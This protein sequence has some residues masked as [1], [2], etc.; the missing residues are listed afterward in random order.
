MVTCRTHLTS[1]QAVPEGD[2]CAMYE[3]HHVHT[4]SQEGRFAVNIKLTA[5]EQ[6]SERW[7]TKN[8]G[9]RFTLIPFTPTYSQCFVSSSASYRYLQ[10]PVN[11]EWQSALCHLCWPHATLCL[12]FSNSALNDSGHKALFS[13]DASGFWELAMLQ[14]M[15]SN[16]GPTPTSFFYS[17]VRKNIQK[18]S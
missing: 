18:I 14:A 8:A 1:T 12:Y 3:W 16:P 9:H 15:S 6:G 10:R 7:K 5:N 13:W 17:P 2:R 11:A 4:F